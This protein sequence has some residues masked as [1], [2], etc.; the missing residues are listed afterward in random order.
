MVASASLP[1]VWFF[2]FGCYL[3]SSLSYGIVVVRFMRAIIVETRELI[4]E[5]KLRKQLSV[6]KW[7]TLAGLAPCVKVCTAV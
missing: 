2:A 3:P 7:T 6:D 1:T 5:T 4:D